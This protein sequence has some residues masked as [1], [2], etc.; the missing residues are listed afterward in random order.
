MKNI[1]IVGAGTGGTTMASKLRR[2]LKE[3]EWSITVLDRD[4]V[5]VY[6][7]GLLFVPFGLLRE[8]ELYRPRD[9]L[10]PRGVTFVQAPIA[11]IAPDENAVVMESGE[12]FAYDVLVLATGCEIAPSQT[13]GLTEQGFYETAFDFYTPEGSVALSHALSSFKAGKLVVHI[14]EMPIKCPVAPLEFAFHADA[15]FTKRGLR[16][17]VEIVYATPLDAA[18]TKPVASRMLG[19]LMAERNIKIE[20]DFN[21]ASVD[22]A[23]RVMK[24]YDG[25]EIDYDLLVTVP[26]HQG[27]AVIRTSGLGDAQG[28]VPTDKHTLV[29]KAHTNVFALGDATDLPSSK[30]GSVAHFQSDILFENILDFIDGRAPSHHFDGHS[31]CFIETGFDKAMLIDF[32]YETEPL[33][34]RFPIPGVGPFTLLEESHVNHWGKLAFKWM[35]WNLLVKGE[36]IPL[37]ANMTMLGKWS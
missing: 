13:E 7:P 6:Q 9:V 33:P 32:N 19:G 35:Y 14:A 27:S 23:R 29:T 11:R 12:R 8:S 31:N 2:A 22:G 18:F 5:H 3:T 26:P 21:V 24:A 15:Y 1:V 4:N 28:F 34:G 25:R 37:E 36:P 17:K 16:D 20:P 30:A 10:L